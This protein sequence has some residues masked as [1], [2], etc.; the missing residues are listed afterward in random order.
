MLEGGHAQVAGKL[1]RDYEANPF[2]RTLTGLESC[3]EITIF[4]LLSQIPLSINNQLDLK[5]IVST[6]NP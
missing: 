4:T 5:E 2:S 1:G 3:R 6:F